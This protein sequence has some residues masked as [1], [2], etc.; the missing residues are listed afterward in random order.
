MLKSRLNL[1]LSIALI[2][3]LIPAFA[4]QFTTGV[5]W[6]IYDFLIAG[7]LLFGTALLLDLILKKVSNR[8]FKFGL[9]LILFLCL[10]LVWVEL[11]V[12]I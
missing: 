11:A 8:N 1:F 9:V 10:I 7:I 3:L 12:G 4:M 5:V 2:I 6:D